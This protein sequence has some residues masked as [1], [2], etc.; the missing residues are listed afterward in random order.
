[1]SSQFPVRYRSEF[2]IILAALGTGLA[3]FWLGLSLFG[4]SVDAGTRAPDFVLPEVASGRPVALSDFAGKPVLVTFWASWCAPCIEEMPMLDALQKSRPDLVVIGIAEDAPEAVKVFLSERPVDYLVLQAS[5]FVDVSL[6][7][8]NDR[9]VLP[10]SVF[11][12]AQG[13]IVRAKMGMFTQQSL[14]SFIQP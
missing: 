5:E 14:E 1:M 8:G 9:A 11:V 6:A 13:N 7:W 2:W 10:Y 3:G 4:P 12:D